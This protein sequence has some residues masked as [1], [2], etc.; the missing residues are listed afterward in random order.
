M[1]VAPVPVQAAAIPTHGN[2]HTGLPAGRIPQE[3]FDTL[4]SGSGLRI[5]RIVSSGHASPPGFWY[6]PAGAEWVLLVAGTATLRFADEPEVRHLATGDWLFIAPGRRH[7]VEA[8]DVDTVW[9]A[10]HW[11]D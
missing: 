8:T 9:L 10:V 6:D 3:R 5:E 4:L 7:R 11:S 1:T 2:L